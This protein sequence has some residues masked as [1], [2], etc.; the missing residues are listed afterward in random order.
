MS[1]LERLVAEQ[2]NF[3]R[4]RRYGFYAVPMQKKERGMVMWECGIPGPSTELYSGSYYTLYLTFP[5]RYPFV[6]PKARFRSP[7]F[8]PNIYTDDNSVCLDIIGDRW[9]PSLNVMSVLLGIQQLLDAP[10]IRSPA[11]AKASHLFRN[12][13]ESYSKKVRENIE[14]Y[15]R[16]PDWRRL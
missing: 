4:N 2:E 12:A 7:V 3:R 10:N 5:S 8:H 6:P 9:K 16:K 1:S 13:T 15:H 11:N 14:Q